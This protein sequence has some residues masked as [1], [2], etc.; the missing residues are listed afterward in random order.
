VLIFENESEERGKRGLLDGGK[1]MPPS[2]VNLA[3]STIYLKLPATGEN[4]Y[5]KS[6]SWDNKKG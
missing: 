5:L 1:K 3:P 6:A 2:L 4:N